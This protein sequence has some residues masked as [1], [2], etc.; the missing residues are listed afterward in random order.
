MYL[1]TLCSA[2]ISKFTMCSK[3]KMLISCAVTAF[4]S[5]VFVCDYVKVGPI[6][7]N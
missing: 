3:T 4:L 5:F 2:N 1:L 7:Q 6:V